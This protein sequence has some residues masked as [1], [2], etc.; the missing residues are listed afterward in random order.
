MNADGSGQVN[1]TNNSAADRHPSW[2]ADG[3][4]IAFTRGNDIFVMNADG[5]G[6]TG[7]VTSP[8]RNWEPAWKP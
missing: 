4:K 8:G 1:L 3:A 2:S 7:V 6:Q 5:T